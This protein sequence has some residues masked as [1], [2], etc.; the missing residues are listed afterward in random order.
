[1]LWKIPGILAPRN[2]GSLNLTPN[3]GKNKG[4]EL[5]LAPFTLELLWQ[6]HDGHGNGKLKVVGA[7]E[8][9]IQAFN[10][11]ATRYPE[12]IRSVET[13]MSRSQWNS[14]LLNV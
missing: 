11:V 8:R 6:T 14:S 13:G 3:Q 1:M 2:P 4:W 7:A 12:K 5:T 9:H 10:F